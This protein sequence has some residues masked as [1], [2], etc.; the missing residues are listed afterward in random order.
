[1]FTHTRTSTS[2]RFVR[3]LRLVLNIKYCVM[4]LRTALHHRST[5]P[6]ARNHTVCLGEGS[7]SLI[8]LILSI[9]FDDSRT[10]FPNTRWKRW[11]HFLF[12]LF[13]VEQDFH[14]YKCTVM[15][16]Y[17]HAIHFSYHNFSVFMLH[18]TP[19]SIHHSHTQTKSIHKSCGSKMF[20]FKMFTVILR[21]EL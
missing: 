6:F 17:Y 14:L 20:V 9:Y 5:V 21:I 7:S 19:G 12:R 1:M 16:L 13:L 10:F 8:V 2:T 18:S 11:K 15:Q 3:V 4:H